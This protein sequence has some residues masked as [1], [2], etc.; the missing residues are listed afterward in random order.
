MESAVKPMPAPM[1]KAMKVP[2]SEISSVVLA[3]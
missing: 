1:K 3:P 2:P